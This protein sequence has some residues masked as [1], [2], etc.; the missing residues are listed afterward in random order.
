MTKSRLKRWFAEL[1]A[2]SEFRCLNCGRE[3]FDG[4]GFCAECKQRVVFNNGKTCKR[5]GVGIDGA[6]DYCGNCAFDRMYFDKAYSVFSYEGAVRDAILRFKFGGC[7]NYARVFAKYLAALAVQ[8]DLQF[9]IVTYAPMSRL[10]FKKRGYNQAQLLA[11]HFCDILDCNK[12]CVKAIVKAKETAPQEKLDRAARKTN[13]VDTYKCVANV[14]GK[15]VLVIDDIK[16]T[17]A[18][19]NECGKVLKRDGAATVIG[20]TVA[21]RRENFVYEVEDEG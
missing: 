18:T 16:T 21:A 13:L 7:G 17:G 5:C 4:L 10:A 8:Q 19:L 15:R 1:I 12:K 9:D 3:V 20:L 11:E 14:A 2:P 6:E